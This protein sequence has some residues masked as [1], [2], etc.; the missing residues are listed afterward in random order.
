MSTH[1][2]DQE[3]ITSKLDLAS[4]SKV[5]PPKVQPSIEQEPSTLFTLKWVPKNKQKETNHT[6][7][8]VP[9]DTYSK[10]QSSQVVN[11]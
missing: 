8:W 1:E 11:T 9:K 5:K 4:T 2:L 3:L 6:L 10:A 7:I